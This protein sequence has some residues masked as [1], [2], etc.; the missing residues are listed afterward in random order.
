MP[1]HPS[2]SAETS[3]LRP[4]VRFS[5]GPPGLWR[6]FRRR[7]DRDCAGVREALCNSFR[8]ACMNAGPLRIGT[9][10]IIPILACLVSFPPSRAVAQTFPLDPVERAGIA[11]QL[12]KPL[13]LDFLGL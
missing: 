7:K 6:L 10:A 9:P 3:R 5:T 11:L 4:S 2:P 13:L 1:M 8:G 12:E